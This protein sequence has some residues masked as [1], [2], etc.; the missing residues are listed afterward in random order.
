MKRFQLFSLAS[1]MLLASAAGFTSC[2]SD[3][4]DPLDGGSGVAGQV[5]KTQFYLNIPYAGN[6]EGGNARVS[7]RMSDVNTQHT[8]EMAAN[9]LGLANMEMF[10][11]EGTPGVTYNTSTR[12]I[13]IGDGDE[14]TTKDNWRRLYSDI[15][16]PVGTKNFI[17]YARA[18]KKNKTTNSDKSNFEAGFLSNP[19]ENFTDEVKPKLDD[20]N[21]ELSEIHKTTD[22][23]SQGQSILE[24]LNKIARTSVT[25]GTSPKWAT[26][27]Q[28]SD[29][30]QDER[31]AL[32]ILYNKFTNLT[33]GSATSVKC[34]IKDLKEAIENQGFTNS[35]AT[36]IKGN[37]E[38]ALTALADCKFPRNLDL[39]DGVAKVKCDKST[40]TFTYEEITPATGSSTNQ[41]ID[42]R[43]VTYPSELAYFVSSPVRTSPNEKNA[44]NELP[45][46]E[47]WLAGKEAW[48]DFRDI[49]LN[50]T[51]FVALKNP[52]QYGVACLE[53][54]VKCSSTTL[55]D[56]ASNT[57]FGYKAD[58]TITI[59]E[60][61]FKITGVLI[62][63]QPKGVAWDFKPASGA[64]FNYTIYDKNMNTGFVANASKTK[65]NYTLVLD[66]KEANATRQSNV[67]VTIELENDAADFY[68]AEGLIPKGS[69]FYLVGLLDLTK[70]KTNPSGKLIDHVFVKDHTTVAN[71]TIKDLKKAYNCI[72]DLRT[73]KINV[74]LAVDLTWQEG[75]TF[76]V[77]L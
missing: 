55:K 15:A 16:I 27:D 75:I 38:S 33:A 13:Q 21:F 67:Y 28:S 50:N 32:K 34:L 61:G 77:N 66:N 60:G 44:I 72:P 30:T 1:A 62:G 26:I 17:L 59:P 11:F 23:N 68:G 7:T 10:A 45:A 29:Y 3:S 65:S 31:D 22:F 54:N 71:F 41:L 47:D 5:V 51:S 42:Y 49:V 39:P 40:N 63:G 53:S 56:N 74:G 46:Y 52:V 57:K 24:Q 43:T 70:N 48:T 14:T 9:F 18:S 12:S 35:M 37:C 6:D 73:S 2:S 64:K 76:D 20:L 36:A 69:K 19:Y 8:N 25:D 4:E 58:N